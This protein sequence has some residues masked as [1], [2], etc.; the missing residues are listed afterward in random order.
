MLRSFFVLY[1]SRHY[2]C[3]KAYHKPVTYYM[4]QKTTSIISNDF[5][6]TPGIIMTCFGYN[7]VWWFLLRVF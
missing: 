2:P 3:A 6:L 7:V 5:T 1:S 4:V